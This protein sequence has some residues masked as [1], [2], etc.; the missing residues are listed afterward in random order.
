VD[1]REA[2]VELYPKLYRYALSKTR[3]ADRAEDFVLEACKRILEREESLGER[4]NLVAYAIT[5]IRN[6]T[7]DGSRRREDQLDD[8]ID[9]PA[10]LTTPGGLFEI[11]NL[12]NSLGQECE[13]ILTIFAMGYSYSEISTSLGI[14]QGTVMSRMSRCRSRLQAAMNG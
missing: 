14:A 7:V 12:L 8:T 3:D 4:V 6:L 13:K 9:G 11:S 2:L 1:I 5:I 10:D